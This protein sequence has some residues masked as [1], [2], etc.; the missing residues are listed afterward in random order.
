MWAEERIVEVMGDAL[1]GDGREMIAEFSG[2]G[3]PTE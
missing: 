2:L 3:A 1:F